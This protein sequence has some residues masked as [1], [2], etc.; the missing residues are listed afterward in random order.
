MLLILFKNT[1]YNI[2]ITLTQ[3]LNI[4]KNVIQVYNTK[5]IEFLS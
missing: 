5:N 2:K 1:L 4:N 3:V